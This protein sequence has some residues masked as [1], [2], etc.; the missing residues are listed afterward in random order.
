MVIVLLGGSGSGKDTQGN[1]LAQKLGVPHVSAGGVL[2]EQKA[3]GDP[4]ALEAAPIAE[5]GNWVPGGLMAEIITNYLQSEA[6]N[7][8]VLNGYPRGMEQLGYFNSV[9]ETLGAELACAVHLEV[10]DDILLA[11]M[12]EQAESQPERLDLTPERMK[13]RLASY[14]ADNVSVLAYFAEQGKLLNIDGT[15]TIDDVAETIESGLRD[16]GVPFEA[17]NHVSETRNE[18]SP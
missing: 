4:K 8:V 1:I 14:H 11:R 3:K 5:G 15:S 7:G 9:L 16:Y 2:R 17:A 13:Q 6:P 18:F 10:P 12:Q